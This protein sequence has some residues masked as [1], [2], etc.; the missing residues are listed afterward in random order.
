MM[1]GSKEREIKRRADA[2]TAKTCLC[3]AKTKREHGNKII[4]GFPHHKYT[5]PNVTK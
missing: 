2:E 4:A 3:G 5:G 1:W